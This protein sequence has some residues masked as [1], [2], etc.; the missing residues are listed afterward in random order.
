MRRGQRGEGMAGYMIALLV[1]A[2]VLLPVLYQ[3]LGAVRDLV[4]R[5]MEALR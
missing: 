4:V 1:V 3:L 5:F 2:A